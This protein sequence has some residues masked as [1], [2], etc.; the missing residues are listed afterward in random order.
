MGKKKGYKEVNVDK[1]QK[2]DGIFGSLRPGSL[3]FLALILSALVLAALPGSA[4]IADDTVT[5]PAADQSSGCPCN[6]QCGPQQAPPIVE[7]QSAEAGTI[8][9][10]APAT[11]NPPAEIQQPV[12]NTQAVNA[13]P[14]PTSE[15]KPALTGPVATNKSISDMMG[16]FSLAG[17]KWFKPS[18]TVDNNQPISMPG[19]GFLE[20]MKI[21]WPMFS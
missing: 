4:M 12:V 9:Q 11:N 21:K 3:L 5:A 18:L 7:P 10:P 6:G 1:Q 17:L 13:T 8:N 14:A 20:K 2:P 19:N 15:S 16:S